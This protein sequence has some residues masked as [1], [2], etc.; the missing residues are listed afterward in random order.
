MK[1]GPRIAQFIA[2]VVGVAVVGGLFYSSY[3]GNM[4]PIKP[5]SERFNAEISPNFDNNAD[6]QII[7]LGTNAEMISKDKIQELAK[8]TI[9]IV[10]KGEHLNPTI[11]FP[12]A[13]IDDNEI[14]ETLHKYYNVEDPVTGKVEQLVTT[15]RTYII[16]HRGP[17][18]VVTV[19]DAQVFRV[20]YKNPSSRKIYLLVYKFK[21]KDNVDHEIEIKAES[22]SG[23][24]SLEILDS[25]P[26]VED[27]AYFPLAN[28]KVIEGTPLEIGTRVAEITED[29]TV[30]SMV[31]L[32][33]AKDINLD[34]SKS[35]ISVSNYDF[36]SS[37]NS[38]KKVAIV[39]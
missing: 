22:L 8:D 15:G 4:L 18:I 3:V 10:K 7:K 9:G 37:P 11:L 32:T 26:R 17:K 16:H 19:P 21:G 24:Y 5:P 14:E 38:P 6:V 34:T 25:A 1:K 2:I 28:Y 35:T 36:I 39:K 30:I 23:M 31:F 20:V 13:D 12:F 29:N 27:A 33:P